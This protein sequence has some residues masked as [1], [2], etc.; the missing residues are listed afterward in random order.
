[1]ARHQPHTLEYVLRSRT[2]SGQFLAL[3]EYFPAL[4]IDSSTGMTLVDTEGD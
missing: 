1:M 2:N 3:T 4:N